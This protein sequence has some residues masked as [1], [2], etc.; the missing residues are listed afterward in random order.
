MKPWAKLEQNYIN[1]PKFLALSASAI[2]LWLEGKNYCDM[3]AT[4]GLIPRGALQTFRFNSK[5]NVTY[6]TESCG[7]KTSGEPYAPLW[8]ASIVGFKMHEYLAYNDCRDAVLARIED[9]ADVAE[10]R[11]LA[12]KDRQQ[13]FRTERKEK[14]VTERN[15]I[16]TPRKRYVTRDTST[17]TVTVQKQEDPDQKKQPKEQAVAPPKAPADPNVRI[18]LLWFQT[19]YTARRHGAEYLVKWERDGALVKQMLGA[20]KLEQLQKY[21]KI[22]LSDKTDDQFIVDSDRGIQILST[23]FSWL[24]DRLATWEAT[25]ARA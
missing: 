25:R 3:H 21:A 13:K 5:A 12:N 2:C 20:T 14:I 6:L 18:F 7:D 19:E 8:E 16:V 22:L 4:D 11:R 1:H 10:L 17:P 15:A 24:S 23:K 9:A